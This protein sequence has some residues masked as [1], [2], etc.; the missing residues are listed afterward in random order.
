VAP[1]VGAVTLKKKQRH[2]GGG[3]NPAGLFNMLWAFVPH[4]G[5]L[6]SDWIP[7]FAG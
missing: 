6:F 2:S 4:C 1:I 3:R 5:S 7:A